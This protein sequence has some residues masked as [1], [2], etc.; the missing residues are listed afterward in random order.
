MKQSRRRRVA[1]LVKHDYIVDV[2]PAGLFGR[3]VLA[4]DI[5]LIGATFLV[6]ETGDGEATSEAPLMNNAPRSRL[7]CRG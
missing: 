4:L 5:G 3:S 6:L 2:H 7:G 1:D